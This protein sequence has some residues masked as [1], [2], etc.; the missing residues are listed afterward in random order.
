MQVRSNQQSERNSS[1]LLS[2]SLFILL[3]MLCG[4]LARLEKACLWTTTWIGTQEQSTTYK[5]EPQLQRNTCVFII[6]ISLYKY[7]PPKGYTFAC[8]Q[9]LSTF[10][11]KMPTVQCMLSYISNAFQIHFIDFFNYRYVIIWAF[12]F[13]IYQHYG[14]RIRDFSW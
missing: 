9:R 13:E 12:A 6:L 10:H 1:S 2:P 14:R 4:F 11:K 3:R 5:L 7:V 8:H